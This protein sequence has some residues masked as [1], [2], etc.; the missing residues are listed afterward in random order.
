MEKIESE[1]TGTYDYEWDFNGDGAYD[2][3]NS[4]TDPYNLS[5]T[6]MYPVQA[7]DR[8]FISKIRVTSGAEVVTAEYRVLIHEPATRGVKVN[9]A[10]DDA[11]WYLHVVMNR[12]SSSGVEYGD[13]PGQTLGTTGMAVQ[14]WEIQGHKA[15]GDYNGNPYVEDVR[16]GLNY[17]LNRTFT[18]DISSQPAGDPD[19]NGNKI[20]LFSSQQSQLY[21]TGI[22]LMALANSGDPAMTADAGL[23]NPDVAGETY[24]KIVQDMVDFLSY[25]QNEAGNGRGGWRYGPKMAIQICRSLS[26]RSSDSRR[27]KKILI[28][29][30]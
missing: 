10:I 3:S 27:L 9:R 4:T 22:V 1:G 17:C 30:I 8:L 25:A 13:F 26:G 12:Y 23:P 11:L 2:S 24:K 7:G 5:A 14:A 19:A 15:N 28:F 20:G 21:E 18:L 29:Q 16:R 6:H